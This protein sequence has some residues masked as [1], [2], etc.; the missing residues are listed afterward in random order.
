MSLEDQTPRRGDIETRPMFGRRRVLGVGLL[1]LVGVTTLASAL[2][3]AFRP[4]VS[5][6]SAPEKTVFIVD[7]IS[8]PL[9]AWQAAVEQAAAA[10]PGLSRSAVR[11]Q[12]L[13]VAT[14]GLAVMHQAAIDGISV[15]DKDVDDLLSS[16][17]K[18]VMDS[19]DG[20]AHV[21]KAAAECGLSVDGYWAS[22][23]PAFRQSLVVSKLRAK[24]L[25]VHP[26][27]AIAQE[28]AWVRY[29]DDLTSRASVIIVDVAAVR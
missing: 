7:G 11:A 16:Q 4:A 15:S 5:Q 26:G 6:S 23:R 24:Y 20:A 13:Q 14:R 12:V 27:S 9:S 22:T 19:I 29:V 1:A 18:I 25:S 2:W 21:R 10:A 17:R 8:E 3:F 28:K